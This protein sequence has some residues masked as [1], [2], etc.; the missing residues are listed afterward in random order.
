[1]SLKQNNAL[2]VVLLALINFLYFCAVQHSAPA[3]YFLSPLIASKQPM[4]AILGL[5]YW[6]AFLAIFILTGSDYLTWPMARLRCQRPAS[7]LSL[8]A[9]KT[10]GFIL[11]N[12]FF[13]LIGIGLFSHFPLLQVLYLLVF[14]ACFLVTYLAWFSH[15][16]SHG[17]FL[18]MAG[19]ILLLSDYFLTL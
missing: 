12:S 9:K 10:I 2:K 4:L 6:L 8:L 17:K 18:L 7:W 16:A 11:L 5:G 3:I 15:F 19:F 14:E 13:L 1:M